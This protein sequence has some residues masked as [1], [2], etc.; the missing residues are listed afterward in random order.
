MGKVV[1]DF[2]TNFTSNNPDILFSKILNA[3]KDVEIPQLPLLADGTDNKDLQ[4]KYYKSHFFETFDFSDDRLLRTPVFHSKI[5]TYLE[6]L[7]AKTPDSIIVSCDYLVEKSRVNPDVFRYVVSYLTS[8][9]ERSKI[10]GLEKV[11]VHLV[12]KY[13][14]T[15]EVTWVDE[16]Q[17]FKIID[18]AET[19]EPLMIGSKAPNLV[20]RDSS[21]VIHNMY[22]IKKT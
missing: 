4:F 14:K 20:L 3:S 5:N 11:F 12:N 18:R 15:N 22:D 19:I 13:Y 7:T 8:T 10:M 9:Y 17:M 6:N 1:M 21:D 16:A 2:Q